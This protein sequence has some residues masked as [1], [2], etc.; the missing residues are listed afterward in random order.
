M[1]VQTF[2][3]KVFMDIEQNPKRASIQL[4]SNLELLEL[5]WMII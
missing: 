5:L 1:Y 3:A 2:K 4:K